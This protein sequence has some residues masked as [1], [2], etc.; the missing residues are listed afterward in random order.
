MDFGKSPNLRL[1]AITNNIQTSDLIAL[2][3]ELTGQ[4]YIFDGRIKEFV[5]YDMSV[6]DL[7]HMLATGTLHKKLNFTGYI[8]NNEL[9]GSASTK[10][11]VVISE[12][13]DIFVKY[14]RV[15]NK[16]TINLRLYYKQFRQTYT[17]IR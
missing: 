3:F 9:Y 1:Y 8:R 13:G 6:L 16:L 7:E 2:I 14:D 5:P 15:L 11:D 10:T 4:Q 12:E 17:N